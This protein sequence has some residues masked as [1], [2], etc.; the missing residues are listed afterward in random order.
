LSHGTGRIGIKVRRTTQQ[1]TCPELPALPALSSLLDGQPVTTGINYR[2]CDFKK[3]TIH[4]GKMSGG[5]AFYKNLYFQVLV[6]IA[7][8][9]LLG[10]FR[11]A[12]G[13][14]MKPFGD[15]FIKL[16]KMMIAPIIFCTVVLGISGRRT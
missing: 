3:K 2:F 1:Q 16:I 15:G 9:I 11:P 14:E 13:A 5:K 10:Y 8:G 12:M 7:I 6:A 4:G